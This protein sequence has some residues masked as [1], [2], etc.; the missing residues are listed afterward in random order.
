MESLI[1]L[2]MFVARFGCGFYMRDWIFKRQRVKSAITTYQVAM[3][4]SSRLFCQISRRAEGNES[5]A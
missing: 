3:T 4:A 5:C 1:Y 2:S